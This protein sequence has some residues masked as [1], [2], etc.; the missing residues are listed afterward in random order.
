[1]SLSMPIKILK[2]YTLQIAIQYFSIFL[3]ERL[4]LLTD[5][6]LDLKPLIALGDE[7]KLI[8]YFS[9]YFLSN[10]SYSSNIS[11]TSADKSQY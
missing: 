4:M 11:I 6:G 8:D 9:D 7:Y 2:E 3:L 5:P 1:M 10:F